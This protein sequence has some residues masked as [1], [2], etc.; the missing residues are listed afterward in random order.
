M[1]ETPALPP[2]PTEV[3]NLTSPQMLVDMIKMI[4][5]DSGTFQMGSN[6]PNHYVDERP[7]HSVILRGFTMSQYEITQKQ[8]RAVMTDLPTGFNSP[9]CDNCPMNFVSWQDG[10]TTKSATYVPASTNGVYRFRTR[11]RHA[12]EPNASDWSPVVSITIR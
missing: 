3:P 7:V 10:V 2:T 8:W 12:T 4:K 5:I 9:S 1:I 11:V 6:D